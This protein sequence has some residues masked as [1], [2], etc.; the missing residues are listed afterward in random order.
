MVS[1]V[2]ECLLVQLPLVQGLDSLDEILDPMVAA[3]QTA[4]GPQLKTKVWETPPLALQLQWQTLEP[5]L[6]LGFQW[7]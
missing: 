4:M 5:L 7:S 6:W 1:V 3:P 2:G